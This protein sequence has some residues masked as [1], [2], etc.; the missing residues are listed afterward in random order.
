MIQRVLL[1]KAMVLALLHQS[2]NPRFNLKLLALLCPDGS[3]ALEK[4]CTPAGLGSGSKPPCGRW[5]R[6]P[7]IGGSSR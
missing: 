7:T 1:K 2:D 6:T 3:T 5:S 4:L